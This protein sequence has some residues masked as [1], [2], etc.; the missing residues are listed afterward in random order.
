[1]NDEWMKEINE[2]LYSWDSGNYSPTDN[3]IIETV[4]NKWERRLE[5]KTWAWVLKTGDLD[6][7]SIILSVMP[8][9]KV[10]NI[11]YYKIHGVIT[12][13][14]ICMNMWIILSIVYHMSP[15]PTE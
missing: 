5:H 4:P 14:T 13:V 12:Y 2:T 11:P 7:L 9:T 15:L 6:I 10:D 8:M 3:L 1:M